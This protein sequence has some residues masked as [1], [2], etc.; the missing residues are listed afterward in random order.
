M[1]AED[2]PQSYWITLKDPE[3]YEGITS[4]VI[5]LDGVSQIRDMRETL[6]PLYECV[7]MLK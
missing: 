3:E 2:M 1:T 4:A 6:K 5:G 7:D